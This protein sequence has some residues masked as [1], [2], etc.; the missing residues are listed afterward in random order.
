MIRSEALEATKLSQVISHE[1]FGGIQ[2]KMIEMAQIE[3]LCTPE[4]TKDKITK[5]NI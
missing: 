3:G 4:K 1:I 2:K 5:S